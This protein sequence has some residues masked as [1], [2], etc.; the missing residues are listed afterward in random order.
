MILDC[1]QSPYINK[2]YHPNA[3][4]TPKF[5]VMV[6]FFRREILSF[7]QKKRAP[8]GAPLKPNY[9]VTYKKLNIHMVLNQRVNF[10]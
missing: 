2:R 6:T 10:R 7:N 1:I 9:Q 3:E 8:V 5:T 4:K